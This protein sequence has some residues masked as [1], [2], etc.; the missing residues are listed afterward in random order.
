MANEWEIRKGG[1]VWVSSP[2]KNCGY[3]PEALKSLQRAGYKL[4]HNG[5]PVTRKESA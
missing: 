5:K 3:S 2:I 1:R 4:Y